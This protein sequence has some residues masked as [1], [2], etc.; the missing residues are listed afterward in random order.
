MFFDKLENKL[1]NINLDGHYDVFNNCREQG[2]VLTLY[3]IGITT[4]MN[5]WASEC[6]N[7][8]DLMIVI[9]NEKDR[10]TNS[11]FSEDAYSK[12]KFFKTDSIDSALKYVIDNIKVTFPKAFLRPSNL[13]F[14]CNYKIQD[15]NRIIMDAKS[16]DYE[17]YHDLATY[18]DLNEEYFCDL[19]IIEGEVGLRYSKYSNRDNNEYENISFEKFEPDLDNEISLMVSMKE[20]LEHFILG[21]KEY[22]LE[23]NSDI[24]I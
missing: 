16:F 15:I 13:N 18:D 11:M 1:N 14:E 24:K 3:E 6:R 21:E 17:D 7:T 22:D 5:I 2:L 12:R 10:D 8:D 4:D 19:I 23:I 20:K 9:G